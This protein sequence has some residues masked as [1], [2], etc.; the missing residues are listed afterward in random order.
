MAGPD[1]LLAKA[2]SAHRTGRTNEAEAAYRRLL[3]SRPHHP[4]ALHF[5]GLLK[6]QQDDAAGG[7]ELVRRSLEIAPG[8]PHAW[9]N[10]GNMLVAGDQPEKALEAYGRATGIDP[11]LAEPWH[12]Q[13]ICLRRA[14]KFDE[15]VQ[16]LQQAIDANPR[17]FAAYES[18]GMLFYRLSRIADAARLYQRWLQM[19]P[20]NPIARHMAAATTQE[21][22]PDR[23][24]DQ[25]VAKLFDGFASSFDSSLEA[26][27]YRAPQLLAAALGDHLHVQAARFDILDAGCGTGLCGP[28]LRS[29][30]KSLTGVDLS[31]GMIEKARERKIYDELV[32]GELSAFMRSRPATFD[33]VLSADTLCYFGALEEPI[34]AARGCLR[35]KGLLAFTVESLRDG[36]GDPAREP[37]RDPGREYRMEPHGRYAHAAAYVRQ[38][39]EANAFNVLALD[40][41]VLRRERGKDVEGWL[42][43]AGS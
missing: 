36:P 31:P 37:G 16:C 42:V 14:R 13:G 38:V 4:D 30:A 8:N 19:D 34:A 6:F 3:R 22:V 9:N 20:Q 40:P 10:L 5:L 26:L 28:L 12:N 11:A 25:Y 15:A 35:S 27:G 43:I 1:Q 17:Y 18:L 41:V 7:M 32:T 39:L 2:I 23:A 24:G 33:V 21:H 29:T